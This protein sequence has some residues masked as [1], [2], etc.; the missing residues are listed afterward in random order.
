MPGKRL[1]IVYLSPSP[2][3]ALTAYEGLCR[4]SILAAKGSGGPLGQV[5]R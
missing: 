2:P 1:G 4:Q 3:P 5:V